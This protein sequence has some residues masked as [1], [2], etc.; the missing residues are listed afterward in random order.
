[1][2]SHVTKPIHD[3]R[4]VGRPF[5]FYRPIRIGIRPFG[6]A[7]PFGGYRPFIGAPFFTG[8]LGGLVSSTLVNPYFYPYGGYGYPFFR[9]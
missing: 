5:G 4:I 1:M 7:R 9:Y 8:V 2:H 3:M 6:F